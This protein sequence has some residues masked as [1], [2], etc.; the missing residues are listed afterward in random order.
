MSR[1]RMFVA[2]VTLLAG[3][4]LGSLIFLALPLLGAA[5]AGIFDPPP[6]YP[7]A[8]AGYPPQSNP[9]GGPPP[10][11]PTGY[12][13]FGNPTYDW[14]GFYVG[15][16]GGGNWSSASWNSPRDTM[17][18]TTATVSTPFIGATTGYNAQTIGSFV[19]GAEF[20]FN[21][22]MSQALLITPPSCVPACELNRPWFATGRVRFGY[23]IDRVMPFVT[24]GVALA[25]QSIAVTGQTMGIHRDLG[26][27]LTA[28]GGIE[29]GV[30]G[31]LSAKVEYLYIRYGQISC[32]D[33]CGAG[34]NFSVGSLT[35]VPSESIVRVGLNLRLWER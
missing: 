18:G 6:A 3:T 28:G 26:V 35:A 29:V 16:N 15:V 31:P 4:L 30:Y 14:T 21:W 11:Y 34:P 20:D 27:G 33:P 5:S 23:T 12:S 19:Y 22:R 13:R 7:S 2:P 17:E 24:G 25:D 10:G 9:P 1:F 32:G 8:P